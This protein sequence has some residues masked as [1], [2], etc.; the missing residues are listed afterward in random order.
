MKLSEN[1]K[2]PVTTWLNTDNNMTEECRGQERHGIKN[3]LT[4]IDRREKDDQFPD[5]DEDARLKKY[6]TEKQIERLLDKLLMTNRN[7]LIKP[8]YTKNG[9]EQGLVGEETSL[10]GERRKASSAT[11]N[12]INNPANNA[13]NGPITSARIQERNR[14]ARDEFFRM[15]FPSQSEDLL[16]IPQAEV[17]DKGFW[18]RS[19]HNLAICPFKNS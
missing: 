16:T 6:R 2:V 7:G 19:F 13:I 5:L 14:I 17:H 3:E 12:A 9:L 18:I 10:Q 4:T 15:K 11:Y 1:Y 8:E